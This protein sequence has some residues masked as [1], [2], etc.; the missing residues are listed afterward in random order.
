VHGF[1]FVDHHQTGTQPC[2]LG[3][4]FILDIYIEPKYQYEPATASYDVAVL[5]LLPFN[6]HIRVEALTLI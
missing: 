2:L 1:L 5:S 3:Q 4:H 6:S